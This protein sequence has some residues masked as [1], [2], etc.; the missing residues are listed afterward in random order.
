MKVNLIYYRL[1]GKFYAKGEY[2]TEHED[3]WMIWGE[4]ELM[5]ETGNLPGL[6]HG[7]KEFIVSVDVPEHP[8]RHPHLI[9]KPE[10]Y[11]ERS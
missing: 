1:S 10:N 2:E 9:I 7:A 3:L 6:V 11:R 5:L 8:H 4:V